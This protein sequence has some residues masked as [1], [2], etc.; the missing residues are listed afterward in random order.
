MN[1]QLK[2][3]TTIYNNSQCKI[4]DYAFTNLINKIFDEEKTD[5]YLDKIQKIEDK[6]RKRTLYDYIDLKIKELLTKIML[7]KIENGIASDENTITTAE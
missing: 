7:S 2:Q 3:R 6:A 4:H 1:G 5:E